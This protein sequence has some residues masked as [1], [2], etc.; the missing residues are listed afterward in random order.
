MFQ[1]RT[2][3]H[4]IHKPLT[5]PRFVSSETFTLARFVPT[6]EATRNYA[7]DELTLEKWRTPVNKIF[8]FYLQD[9]LGENKGSWKT[10][11]LVLF[12]DM[13]WRK[14]FMPIF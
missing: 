13:I 8:T 11:S 7:Q 5:D 9:R 1:N 3:K 12:R 4:Q 14:T 2:Y 10:S 6:S